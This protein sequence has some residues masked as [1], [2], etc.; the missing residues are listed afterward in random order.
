MNV[1]YQLVGF[2]QEPDLTTPKYYSRPHSTGTMPPYWIS[3]TN[4]N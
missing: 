3:T 4:P 1:E 2:P